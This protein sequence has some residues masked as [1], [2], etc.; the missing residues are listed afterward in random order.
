MKGKILLTV[1]KHRI[2]LVDGFVIYCRCEEWFDS[3]ILH[4]DHVVMMIFDA[5][6]NEQPT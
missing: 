4:A 2:E 1:H 6:D 5:L 3:F